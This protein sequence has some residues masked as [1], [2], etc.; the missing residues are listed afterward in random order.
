MK[1]M[2]LNPGEKDFLTWMG[3]HVQSGQDPK[4]QVYTSKS[5]KC[6]QELGCLAPDGPDNPKTG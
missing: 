3:P 1:Q 4:G 6:F 5:S 2:K